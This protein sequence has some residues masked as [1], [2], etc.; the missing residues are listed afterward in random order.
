MNF[1]QYGE[2][3]SSKGFHILNYFNR[4]FKSSIN[5][6]SVLTKQEGDPLHFMCEQVTGPSIKL[7]LFILTAS[8]S[9]E[10]PHQAN[11]RSHMWRLKWRVYLWYLFDI[12]FSLAS[13]ILHLPL[14]IWVH[15][16]LQWKVT[17]DK[18]WSHRSFIIAPP[19]S[20]NWEAFLVSRMSSYSTVLRCGV[21]SV[22]SSLC[23][24]KKKKDNKFVKT[25]KNIFS[26][27]AELN[28][29]SE[30]CFKK[31]RMKVAEH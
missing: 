30:I 21:S 13:L 9:W 12:C 31:L 27:N 6:W 17:T 20:V 29:L 7:L 16:D 10:K 1:K 26:T 28:D 22:K 2:V 23:W 19:C 8:K 15:T 11:F 18:S 25:R 24:K 4:S 3:L 14:E 5:V